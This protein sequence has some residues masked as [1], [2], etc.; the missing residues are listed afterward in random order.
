MDNLTTIITIIG[1]IIALVG[2]ITP[3]LV[4][5]G[6]VSQGTK[7]QLRSEMLHIYYK[8]ADKKTI[9]QY[10]YQNFLM[11]YEAYKALNGNSFVD[12]I[13]REVDEWQVVT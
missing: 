1:E 3:V 11:L 6:K 8:G 2:T 7:C 12:K 5:L 4:K 13:K 9:R 10:E